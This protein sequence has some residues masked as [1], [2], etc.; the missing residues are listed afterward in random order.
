MIIENLPKIELA[1][2]TKL[3]CSLCGLAHTTGRL[4][5]EVYG[6]TLMNACKIFDDPKKTASITMPYDDGDK[7]YQGYV[8]LESV[9]V[10][11]GGGVRVALRR[12]YEGEE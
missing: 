9:D 8:V 2:G 12:R 11:E 5:V 3:T 1:D 7:V 10:V 6:I 4:L